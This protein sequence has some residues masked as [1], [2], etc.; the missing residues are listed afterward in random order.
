MLVEEKDRKHHLLILVSYSGHPYLCCGV[1]GED[2]E[3]EIH[4]PSAVLALVKVCLERQQGGAV[5]GLFSEGGKRK[6]KHFYK[7]IYY[8]DS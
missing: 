8:V 7:V 2:R 6:K 1:G 5:F 3:A 4:V